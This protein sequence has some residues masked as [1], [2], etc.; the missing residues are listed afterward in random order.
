M[1]HV[2]LRLSGGACGAAGDGGDRAQGADAWQ[3]GGH[4]YQGKL[5]PEPDNSYY[6]TL[7]QDGGY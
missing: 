2:C 6:G 1:G 3:L 7:S 4:L 5:S